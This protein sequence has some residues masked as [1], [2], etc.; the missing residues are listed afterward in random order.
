M[1]RSRAE[2]TI[3]VLAVI[4]ALLAAYALALHYAPSEGSFCNISANINCDKVNK[5]PWAE[6]LGIPVALGGL[7]AYLL[8][9]LLFLKRR[10]VQKVLS[11]T[12][13]DFAQYLFYFILVMFLFQVYLTYIEVAVIKAY[14]LICVGSQLV[15]LLMLIF[16]WKEFRKK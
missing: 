3:L 14:C 4:G 13:K 11:F 12:K 10:M 8:V 1:K 7:V 5:S 9:F 16:G 2:L 15:V 6:F